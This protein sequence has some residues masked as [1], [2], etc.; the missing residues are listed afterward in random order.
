MTN[1]VMPIDANSELK[2]LRSEV[3]SGTWN[4]YDPEAQELSHLIFGK[5]SALGFARDA[6]AYSLDA[7]QSLHA[8]TVPELLLQIQPSGVVSLIDQNGVEVA[9]GREDIRSRSWL[10][11]ILEVLYSRRGK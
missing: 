5:Y 4:D 10:I 3:K 2:K 8:M 7:A 9:L 11:A 1:D 6:Y